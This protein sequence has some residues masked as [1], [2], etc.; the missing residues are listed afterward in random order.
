MNI[1]IYIHMGIYHDF[2]KKYADMHNVTYRMA[3]RFIAENGLWDQGEMHTMG[4]GIGGGRLHRRITDMRV[5]KPTGGSFKKKVI[6]GAKAYATGATAIFLADKALKYYLRR[7]GSEP[8]K[9]SLKKKV[10]RGVKTYAT[11]ATALFLA[12]KALKYY[13]RNR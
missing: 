3:Q 8:K 7:G 6:R 13:L 5:H 9:S 11:G 12:D 10:I 1:Y 4:E 2:V